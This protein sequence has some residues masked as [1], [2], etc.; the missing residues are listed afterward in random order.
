[1]WVDDGEATVVRAIFAYFTEERTS[2]SGPAKHLQAQG[3]PT[4]SGKR[5]WGL[6]TLRAILRQPAYIGQLFAGRYRTRPPRIRPSATHLLGRPHDSLKD[7]PQE[8]WLP[9]ATI[10]TIVGQGVQGTAPFSDV[11]CS[12][13]IPRH[14]PEATV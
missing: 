2:R 7:L 6:A 11:H 8:E 14:Q 4:P 10:S 12:G 3:I 9:I 1:M 13:S 5:L